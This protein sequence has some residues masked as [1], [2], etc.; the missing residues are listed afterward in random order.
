[1][2]PLAK[3]YQKYKQND[4]CS[5]VSIRKERDKEN[6]NAHLQGTS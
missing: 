5:T 3:V 4:H 6:L 1:M 2:Y